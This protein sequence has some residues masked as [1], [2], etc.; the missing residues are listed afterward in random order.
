MELASGNGTHVLS[1]AARLALARTL[2]ENGVAD[3]ESA[4][5]AIR[6]L[7]LE[8][9]ESHPNLATHVRHDMAVLQG[10][11]SELVARI[12]SSFDQ[13]ID[14]IRARFT[15]STRQVSFAA[16]IAVAFVL[17]LDAISFVRSVV[18]PAA[19]VS[20]PHIPGI[21]FS[22]LLLSLGAPFW[23]EA[24]KNLLRIRSVLAVKDDEQRA[25][26]SATIADMSAH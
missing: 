14:R 11:K 18:L 26:R 16:S 8:F 22:T 20:P 10:A 7:A 13:T 9:E 6:S 3:P 17:Q 1:E 23:F 21:L 12:N 5:K 2:A 19:A 15:L 4:L 25:R 24:L